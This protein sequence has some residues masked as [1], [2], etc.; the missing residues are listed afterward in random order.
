LQKV[1]LAKTLRRT[2]LVVLLTQPLMTL[3]ALGVDAPTAPDMLKT[4]APA[5]SRVA[6]FR[7]RRIELGSDDMYVLS[8]GDPPR[9]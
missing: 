1:G 2:I 7:T 3:D 5:I 9:N 8:C 6:G 4:S